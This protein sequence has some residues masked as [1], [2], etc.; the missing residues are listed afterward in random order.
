MPLILSPAAVLSFHLSIS[1]VQMKVWN[2]IWVLSSNKF[3]LS[4]TSSDAYKTYIYIYVY[5]Y[6][7]V[8]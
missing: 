6:S 1:N 5:T 3:E 7:K 4:A 2:I 8:G